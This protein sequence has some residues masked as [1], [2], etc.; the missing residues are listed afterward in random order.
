LLM[1]GWGVRQMDWIESINGWMGKRLHSTT[2][3][4]AWDGVFTH[5]REFSEV[6]I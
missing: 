6:E 2:Q 5:T 3:M 4:V 1:D